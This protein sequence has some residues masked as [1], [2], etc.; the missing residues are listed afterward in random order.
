MNVVLFKQGFGCWFFPLNSLNDFG[1]K[2][3]R[4][5]FTLIRCIPVVNGYIG[6][7]RAFPG[8]GHMLVNGFLWIKSCFISWLIMRMLVVKKI[9][10]F[11][12]IS[13]VAQ[14]YEQ[15]RRCFL[16]AITITDFFQY[17]AIR[18]GKCSR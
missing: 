5:V 18:Q 14:G 1:V 15:P 10:C 2:F 12:W 9:N 4:R 13:L 3:C 16:D 11:F 6:I 8:I 7:G 17:E